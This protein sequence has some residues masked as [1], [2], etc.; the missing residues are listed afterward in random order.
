MFKLLQRFVVPY[1]H[2]LQEERHPPHRLKPHLTPAPYIS[3]NILFRFI[4]PEEANCNARRK[5]EQLQP[6]QTSEAEVWH[7]IFSYI[8]KKR[9][10]L[11]TEF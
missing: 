4:H 3:D 10:I 5:L 7:N 6:I 11:G 2:H 9:M 1:S 8:L